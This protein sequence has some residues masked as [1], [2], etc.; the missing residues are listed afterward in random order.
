MADG[1]DNL[2]STRIQAVNSL[3]PGRLAAAAYLLPILL[4][5]AGSGT[6]AAE[7]WHTGE[8]FF[9]ALK[10]TVSITVEGS[11]IRDSLGRLGK[12]QAVALFVDRR[13][14]PTSEI[15]LVIEQEPLEDVIRK[16]ARDQR[17]GVGFVGSV[18]YVGPPKTAA[19][20]ATLAALKNDEAKEAAEQVARQ[21]AGETAAYLA[22]AHRTALDRTQAMRRSRAYHPR[23]EHDPTRPV[24]APATIPK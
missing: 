15:T 23:G 6:L 10:S 5:V 22:A 13:V 18:M 19:R 1:T 21:A 11:P 20:V 17:L 3:Y 2:F 14:D 8:D 24:D 16:I 9:A 12:S 7:D 4:A